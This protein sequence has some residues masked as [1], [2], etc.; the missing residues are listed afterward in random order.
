MIRDEHIQ[1]KILSDGFALVGRLDEAAILEL[2]AREYERLA[3]GSSF[4]YSLLNHKYEAN[5]GIRDNIKV[6]LRPYFE[7]NFADYRTITESYLIKPAQTETELLLHQD[8]CYT[9]EKHHQA[10]NVWIPLE[11]VTED[12]GALFFLKGSHLWFPTLRSGSLLTAR[13]SSQDSAAIR[14]R[15][16]TVPMKK[17]DV[18]LFHPAVFHGS[19]PNTS[20][21][22]R[23]IVTTTVMDSEAPFLYY[24]QENENKVEVFRLGDER[25]IM[26]LETLTRGERP[27]GEPIARIEYHHMMVTQ[28]MIDE[29]LVHYQDQ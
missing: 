12:N 21:N 3:K 23:V 25:F 20:S 18:L 29:K 11:D 1:R 8:W 5:K 6:V 26:D 13:I 19:H 22:D 14:T 10:Y 4:F 2:R 15:I 27:G 7:E 17:G 16:A 24:H 9:D 28:E